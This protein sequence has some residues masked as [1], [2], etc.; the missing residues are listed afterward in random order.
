M[1][2]GALV[3]VAAH[4]LIPVLPANQKLMYMFRSFPTEIQ[5]VQRILQA[6]DRFHVT[7]GSAPAF[8][9]CPS[10]WYTLIPPEN[11]ASQDFLRELVHRIYLPMIK[12]ICNH[13]GSSNSTV[14]LAVL[15]PECFLHHHHVVHLV[16]YVWTWRRY[17]SRV[18]HH[19]AAGDRR[20]PVSACM[21]QWR[22]HRPRPWWRCLRG[23]IVLIQSVHDPWTCL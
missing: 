10:R 7:T 1:Q 9:C 21:R 2:Y 15:G 17:E 20:A 16:A 22:L 18:D 12:S 6:A 4:I 8:R 11:G 5:A 14:V 13:L 3:N 19:I 23:Q